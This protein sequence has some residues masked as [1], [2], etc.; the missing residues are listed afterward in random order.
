[1]QTSIAFLFSV[2]LLT[3]CA[4]N[5]PSAS[6]APVDAAEYYQPNQA[7]A[8]TQR[9]YPDPTGGLGHSEDPDIRVTDVRLTASYTILYMTFSKDPNDRGYYNSTSSV[10]FNPKALLGTHGSKRT[11]ALLKAEGIPL[12]PES[13]DIQGN[14]PVKFTLY[15]ER[16]DEGVERFDLFECQS[17]N[18]NS[19]FNVSNITVENTVAKAK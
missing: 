5:R 14:E 11:Y 15:F 6:N 7:Y 1:M 16:L 8:P 17:D 12:A 10:S 19:C 3:A 18:Q 4:T 13:R 2:L 9:L